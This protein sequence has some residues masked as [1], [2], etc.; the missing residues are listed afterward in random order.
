MM[1]KISLNLFNL[2]VR[3]SLSG[4]PTSNGLAHRPAVKVWRHTLGFFYSNNFPKHQN[5]RV[6]AIFHYK[7]IISPQLCYAHHH[8]ISFPCTF[9]LRVSTYN[10]QMI[11]DLQNSS[12]NPLPV[13]FLFD[14]SLVPH[15]FTL[16]RP[17]ASPVSVAVATTAPGDEVLPAPHA[18]QQLKRQQGFGDFQSDHE[19]GQHGHQLP[20][21]APW[22]MEDGELYIY[23]YMLNKTTYK[24]NKT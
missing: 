4:T 17:P 9:K 3:L 2:W 21:R 13:F 1:L 22:I 20:P 7:P 23:I 24:I 5:S 15:L 10:P 8:F 18:T 14:L 19:E 12:S 11:I 16:Q 6:L